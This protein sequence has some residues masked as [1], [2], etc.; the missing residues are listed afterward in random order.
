MRLLQPTQRCDREVSCGAKTGEGRRETDNTTQQRLDSE[1]YFALIEIKASKLPPNARCNLPLPN[2][3]M[4]CKLTL[5]YTNTYM[6]EI[7]HV[8]AII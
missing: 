1:F 8:T 7:H 6:C 5:Y 4:V 3:H 2:I